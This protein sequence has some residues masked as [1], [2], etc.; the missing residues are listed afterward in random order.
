MSKDKG[1]ELFEESMKNDKN[2][3]WINN[4]DLVKHREK[5]IQAYKD[6]SCLDIV[7]YELVN[8]RYNNDVYIYDK[9]GYKYKVIVEEV[10]SDDDYDD[11]VD[12]DVEY[13]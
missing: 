12:D 2:I 6:I 1:L 3:D 8:E 4:N 13:N 10:W 5:L 11:N 7:D 9:D